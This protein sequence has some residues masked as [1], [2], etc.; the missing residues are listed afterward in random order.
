MPFLPRYLAQLGARDVGEVAF[1][2]GL[3]LG[4]TPAMTALLAPLWGRVADRFGAKLMLQRSLI[5]FIAIMAAMAFVTRPWHVFALRAVQG[6]FAGYGALALA[7]A[8]QSAPPGGM[9]SAIGTVQTAQRLGPALGPVIGGLLAQLVG[10]RNA[11]LVSAL[12]YVVGFVLVLVLY[13][14]PPAGSGSRPAAGESRVTFRSVLAF[15]HF[16][17]LMAVIFVLQ[18]VDRSLGPILPLYLSEL[19]GGP[20]RVALVSGVIFST[21]AVAAAIGHR[22]SHLLLLRHPARV[23]M[24]TGAVAAAAALGLFV[25]WPHLAV[26]L[27]A[28]AAFGA[29]IG[30]AMTAAYA[31]GGDVMPAEAR[32]T[33]F[34]VL[35]SASL[36]AMALSPMAAGF[37][38]AQSR[39]L[40]FAVDV[41]L[42]LL[43]ALFVRRSMSPRE[44]G[45]PAAYDEAGVQVI[46]EE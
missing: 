35:S 39:V 2:S 30:T 43:L 40:V 23:I 33:G 34:G 37:I 36:A 5:S 13:T 14:D 3:S 38:G 27:L 44:A 6:F 42:L 19:G 1:W 9:A 26:L 21:I 46:D 28:A 18:F 45:R 22:F 16:V 31:T 15:E 41:A 10:L 11:F 17:A 20:D 25:G 24:A 8:A 29:S 4:I 32:G 7:M 12:F